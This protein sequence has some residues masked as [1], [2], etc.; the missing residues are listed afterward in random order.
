MEGSSTSEM[1]YQQKLIAL[2]KEDINPALQNLVKIVMPYLT[3]TNICLAKAIYSII[4]SLFICIYCSNSLHTWPYAIMF[5]NSVITGCIYSGLILGIILKS[6]DF[7]LSLKIK[8]FKL[9]LKSEDFM[10]PV[11]VSL[12][13]AVASYVAIIFVSYLT[14][15]AIPFITRLGVILRM[16]GNVAELIMIKTR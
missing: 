11:E 12:A 15:A 7:M 6:M 4:V 3:F 10:L 13:M 16:L 14:G 8:D 9:S 2:Y 1:S 5:A